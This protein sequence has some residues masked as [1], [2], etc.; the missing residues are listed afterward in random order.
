MKIFS[1][2]A[3]LL[4]LTAP[5][6]AQSV[7]PALPKEMLGIWGFEDAES[8]KGNEFRMTA[9]ARRVEFFASAYD[10]R[11]ISRRANGAVKATATTSE[12]GEPGRKRGTI[13][14]KLISPDKISVT[15]G[16]DEPMIYV[17]CKAPG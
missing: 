10:L 15:T 17:R 14:L 5:A 8:C 11:K 2:A 4:S 7:I 3:L 1:A 12:E 16:G 9:S 6:M 13:A